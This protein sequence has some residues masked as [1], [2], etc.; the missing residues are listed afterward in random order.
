MKKIIAA[1]LLL[2]LTMAL[3]ACSGNGSAKD[4]DRVSDTVDSS[5]ALD[6]EIVIP[7]TDYTFTV[8]EEII[9]VHETDDGRRSTKVLRYPVI[10]GMPDSDIQD[11]VN[12][13]F[14]EVAGREFAAAIPDVDIFVIEDIIFN[15]EVT[16]VDVTY[17]SN[18]FISVKNTVYSMNALAEY[19][20]TPVYTVNIDLTTGNRVESVDIFEDFNA[21]TSA[22]IGGYFEMEYGME[23]ILQ[24]TSYEDMILQYK[25]D[26]ASYPD[27]YFLPGK[28][29]ICIDLVAALESSAGFSIKLSELGDALAFTP[30]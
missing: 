24:N 18:N 22:F 13:L 2:T 15:Y 23:N 9:V 21:V 30:N 6:E 29:V 4:T 25:S 8:E 5:S 28:L 14:R 7:E 10:S 27:V 3:F 16:S 1:L 20:D 11:S 19:P 17:F 12:A 26:Y